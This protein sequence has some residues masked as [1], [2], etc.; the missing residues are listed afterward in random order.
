MSAQP[1]SILCVDDESDVLEVYADYIGSLG[2][3]VLTAKSA[4][5]A[6]EILRAQHFKIVLIFSDFSMP[7][8]T[9]FDLRK[10]QLELHANIPLVIISG[11][12]TKETALKALELKIAGFIPKPFDQASIGSAIKDHAESRIQQLQEEAE[13]TSAFVS[14]AENL[15]EE[16]EQH[17]LELESHPGNTELV[18]RVFAIAHTIKGSSGFFN[19]KTIH[20]FTH[21]FEDY[22][23]FY[24]KSL[25]PIPPQAISVLLKG[26]DIIKSL[27][28]ALKEGNVAA[29]DVDDLAKIFSQP[30][31]GTGLAQVNEEKDPAKTSSTAKDEIK[32]STHLLDQFMELSGEITVIRNMINKLVNSIERTVTGN[33]DV[34]QLSE[35]L[36][37]MHKINTQMQDR[38]VDL[39][40]VKVRTV[41]RPL[42]RAVRDLSSQLKKPINFKTKGED[43]R[44][45]TSIAEVLST[46]LI[47]MVRNCVDHG[48]ESAEDREKVGK[49]KEGQVDLSVQQQDQEIV[50]HI[51]DDGK[52]INPE[53][54]RKK[55]VEK[56]LVNEAQAQS[57]SKEALQAMIFEPGFSTSA[58]V[59]DVSGRGVGMDMVKKAVTGAGGQI[60]IESEV[61][62]G[63][64]FTIKVP[65]PKTVTIIT[66]LLVRAGRHAIA[67]PNENIQRV[68]LIDR[69]D[70]QTMI[71]TTNGS[72]FLLLD[73]VLIPIVN[74]EEQLAGH[75]ENIYRLSSDQ[76][77]R[78]M[79]LN[80]AQGHFAVAVSEI[81][82]SEDTVVKKLGAHLKSVTIFKGAT[83]FGDGQVGLILD[84][85]GLAEF[86]QIS[87][88]KT[89][90]IN[91][92]DKS[93]ETVNDQHK[94]LL[95]LELSKPGKFGI[96]MRDLYRLEMI[97]TNEIQWMNQLSTFIY[98]SET[99]AI[100]SVDVALGYSNLA[101]Q[102]NEFGPVITCLMLKLDNHFVA[103][104]VKAIS[105]L[106]STT[107]EPDPLL[108]DRSGIA[109]ALIVDDSTITV[110]DASELLAN[111]REIL[112]PS[113][114][115]STVA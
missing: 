22:L 88:S 48:I 83:F 9:G 85:D 39:R 82:D 103:L 31:A 106:V 7:G 96:F 6:L 60:E 15:M 21:K 97:D 14:D 33:K 4:D 70:R 114:L 19:P 53:I 58:Q 94:Q 50:V 93:I 49:T 44:I 10:E 59:T 36:D 98:R 100:L 41:Y 71:R 16:M 28:T 32:V 101:S 56:K 72:D 3:H 78:L 73:E 75:R 86:T 55:I 46:S 47:H 90:A 2:F 89:E 38:I 57:M 92:T 52:G 81:L 67:V 91:K 63:T 27:V 20:K 23:S 1:Y 104:A 79:I 29:G 51:R 8:K 12:I 18:D 105:D 66:S 111:I 40:K 109:G 112:K 115:E 87:K 5:E 102:R 110:L 113:T 25:Q 30:T 35:L 43:V 84:V 77:Q 13:L 74:L 17:L 95:V 11:H 54:I 34:H 107:G 45:D 24:K 80:S 37:E 42:Q 61:Q 64:H 68:L 108:K 76:F 26:L 69:N 99:T 62:K 65:I